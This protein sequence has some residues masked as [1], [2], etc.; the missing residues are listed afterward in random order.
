MRGWTGSVHLMGN[1]ELIS[2]NPSEPPLPI[3]G[4]VRPCGTIVGVLSKEDLL[5]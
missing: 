2:L 4:E 3:D 1:G 5:S